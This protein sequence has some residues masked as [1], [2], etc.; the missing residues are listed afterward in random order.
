MLNYKQTFSNKTLDYKNYKGY[1]LVTHNDHN[2]YCTYYDKLYI[3]KDQEIV[4]KI[5]YPSIITSICCTDSIVATVHGGDL[6]VMS[7]KRKKMSYVDWGV[8]P[9]ISCYGD[10]IAYIKSGNVYVYN[11]IT[12]MFIKWIEIQPMQ[13]RQLCLMREKVYI[14]YEDA[15]LY[16]D[17]TFERHGVYFISATRTRVVVIRIN[18]MKTLMPDIRFASFNYFETNGTINVLHCYTK[19]LIYNID[20]INTKITKTICPGEVNYLRDKLPPQQQTSIIANQKSALYF[21]LC[22]EGIN[23]K[24]YFPKPIKKIIANFIKK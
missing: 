14:L 20:I 8:L 16:I 3:L 13:I 4:K 15:S 7:T 10:K 17:D 19:D 23:Y 18:R 21:L 5:R 9:Q 1:H 6:S 24:R 2:V 11:C 22:T 12:T